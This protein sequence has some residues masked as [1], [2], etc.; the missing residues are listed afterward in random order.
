MKIQ[1]AALLL[2]VTCGSIA[3][4][5]DLPTAQVSQQE[6][7][8]NKSKNGPETQASSSNKPQPSSKPI[9]KVDGVKPELSS[10]A[11]PTK[12]TAEASQTPPSP[13]SFW[14]TIAVVVTAGIVNYW[15]NTRTMSN[16]TQEATKSRQADHQNKVSEYRHAWLQ[17]LRNTAS[18]LIKAIHDGQS[19]LMRMNLSRDYRE[20]AKQRGDQESVKENHEQVRLGYADER[21]A[22][23]EIHKY[24]SKIKLMFKPADPQTSKL[25]SL[26]DGVI[27]K[28]GDKDLRQLNNVVI[29]E[30]VAELQV[31]LKSEW[32]ITKTRMA[33]E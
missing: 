7:L 31:I 17:E 28:I 9:D 4:A 29:E 12:P 27:E 33:K 16:Q 3:F 2:A 25:F 15:L 21:A 8:S 24:V 5:A 13:L 26:L 19:A 22:A 18:E 1:I 6:I 20:A 23:S 11:P 32:E 30:I 10:A 14:I